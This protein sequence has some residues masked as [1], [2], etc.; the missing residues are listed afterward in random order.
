MTGLWV[1]ERDR[2]CVRAMADDSPSPSLIGR[3]AC[4]LQLLI[5]FITVSIRG[6]TELPLWGNSTETQAGAGDSHWRWSHDLICHRNWVS[7]GSSSRGCLLFTHT[8]LLA[9]LRWWPGRGVGWRL[10]DGAS[11]LWPLLGFSLN[12]G[13]LLA[14]D[15]CLGWRG[16]VL[17]LL[18]PGT[19]SG[20]ESYAHD[21]HGLY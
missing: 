11:N 10:L 5:T 6:I 1:P 21:G 15:G 9:D 12:G 3:T 7:L 4:P 20:Q 18:S 16:S 14:P 13:P 2:E 17:C 19:P 8:W